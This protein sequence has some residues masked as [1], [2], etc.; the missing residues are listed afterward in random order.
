MSRPALRT[1]ATVSMFT[2]T[3]SLTVHPLIKFVAVTVY[4]LLVFTFVTAVVAPL[5]HA[6]PIGDGVLDVAVK[7]K[8]VL[9]HV[10]VVSA[11]ADT[12]GTVISC[13]TRTV[14]VLLQPFVNEVTVKVYNPRYTFFTLLVFAPDTMPGPDQ[15]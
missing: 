13:T 1:G 14:S 3:A 11:P 2:T 10:S 12:C 9:T 4:V 7:F 5:D 15:L 6:K 8:F